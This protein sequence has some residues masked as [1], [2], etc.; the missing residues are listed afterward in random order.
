LIVRLRE[1]G[2][3]WTLEHVRLAFGTE[4]TEPLEMCYDMI[5]SG[6]REGARFFHHV[7]LA[8]ATTR[9]QSRQRLR[10]AGVLLRKQTRGR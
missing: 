1:E 10:V 7:T 8:S 2:R 3:R 6:Q 9:V 4:P 5:G